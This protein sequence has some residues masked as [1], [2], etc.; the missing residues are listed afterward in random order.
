MKRAAGLRA[1]GVTAL[2]LGIAF[3]YLGFLLVPLGIAK[4]HAVLGIL[5]GTLLSSAGIGIFRL[6][7]R[8]NVRTRRHLNL[9]LPPDWTPESRSFTLYLRS[10]DDDEIRQ[11][12]RSARW[13]R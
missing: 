10:F 12:H 7:R 8:L 2:V 5:A 4:K 13:W 3:E 6:G 9:V 11:S 1:L